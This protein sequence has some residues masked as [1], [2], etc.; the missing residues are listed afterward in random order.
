MAGVEKEAWRSDIEENLYANN[1]FMTLIGK[2]DDEYVD[3][4][5][6]H[7]PQSGS[8]P[9]VK[10]NRTTL[11][12]IIS[13]RTDS[14]LDYSMNWYTLDPWV[15]TSEEVQ[16]ISYDKRQDLIGDQTKTLGDTIANQTLYAWAK[17]TADFATT[18]SAVAGPLA[19]GATGNRKPLIAA[20]LRKANQILDDQNLGVGTRYLVV[21][22]SMYW[23]DMLAISEFTKYLEFGKAVVPSGVIGNVYG[24]DVIMRSSV[25]VYASGGTIKTIGDDGTPSSTATTDNL[26]AM[27]IHSPYVRKAKSA[28]KLYGGD[29]ERA[30]YFG[31]VMSAELFHGAS[32]SRTDGKGIVSIYQ[33]S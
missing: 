3:N 6:V 4:R 8:R 23:L 28:I 10:K 14:V 33:G 11:P 9:A 26:G 12:A 30:E 5:T 20:D 15:L 2:T 19:P 29:E 18:G 32:K 24:M 22:A 31:S 25:V 16:F 27:V 13:Q 17:S 7:L 1:Q 21:P